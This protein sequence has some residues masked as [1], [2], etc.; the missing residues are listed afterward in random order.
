MSSEYSLMAHKSYFPAS[1]QKGKNG[2]I[3]C[4]WKEKK[5]LYVQACSI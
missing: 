4:L 1:K 5:N 2:A 3:K